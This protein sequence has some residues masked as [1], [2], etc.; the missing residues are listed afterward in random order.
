M[1]AFFILLTLLF[2]FQSFAIPITNAVTVSTEDV[3]LNR[4][5]KQ[6]K[7]N[8]D[9]E[10]KIL[11][12]IDQGNNTA[13]VLKV[14]EYYKQ[15]IPENQF[16]AV[17]F[18]LNKD[19]AS[20]KNNLIKNAG[21]EGFM[22]QIDADETLSFSLMQNLKYYLS[23][24]TDV[25]LIIVPRANYYIN[26]EVDKGFKKHYEDHSDNRGRFYYPDYQRRI[27]KLDN[28]NISFRNKIHEIIVGAENSK[29]IPENRDMDLIHIKTV[30]KQKQANQFY[31]KVYQYIN[32]T[33]E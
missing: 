18:P 27:I 30:K 13:E 15:L 14:V 9:D 33:K 28:K 22:F 29:M 17:T 23:Q 11:V 2:S 7:N 31:D 10:D 4:L 1:K 8:L 5:L 6:L 24:N 12:Q 21:S 32:S 3:E 16:K 20:F 26:T 25:D 19:F